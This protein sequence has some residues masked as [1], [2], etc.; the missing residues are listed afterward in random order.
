MTS[1][2]KVG[3]IERENLDLREWINTYKREID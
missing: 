3:A 1:P 2:T